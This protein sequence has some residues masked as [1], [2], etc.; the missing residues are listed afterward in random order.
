MS[1]QT[2][3]QRW[4]SL[5]LLAVFLSLFLYYGLPSTAWRI[6]RAIEAGRR[7]R[8]AVEALPAPADPAPQAA[9]FV[10]ASQDVRA[11]VVRVDAD[12]PIESLGE[13]PETDDSDTRHTGPTGP[14]RVERGCGVVIDP[15]GLVLTCRR[16][17][18]G[19][20]QV[21]VVLSREQR[22]LAA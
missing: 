14:L 8:A 3:G 18:S 22:P 20:R 9:P 11:A 16:V 21:R 13:S 15:Q 6:G 10:R 19:A 12:H 1:R 17:V 2:R 5:V 7:E 4:S